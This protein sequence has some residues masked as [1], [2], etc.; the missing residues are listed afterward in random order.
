MLMTVLRTS[1]RTVQNKLVLILYS[2]LA[3]E[4][5]LGTRNNRPSQQY[6]NSDKIVHKDW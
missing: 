2:V 4:L 1:R 5:V 6:F 3:R